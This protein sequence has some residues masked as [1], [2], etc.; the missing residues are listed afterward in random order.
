M[1]TAT[2]VLLHQLYQ[3]LTLASRSVAEHYLDEDTLGRVLCELND[4]DAALGDALHAPGVRPEHLRQLLCDLESRLA[5]LMSSL[6]QPERPYLKP[7]VTNHEV[8]DSLG[9]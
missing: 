5:S 2:H 9:A 1:D 7:M 3:S 8:Y 6:D 4:I